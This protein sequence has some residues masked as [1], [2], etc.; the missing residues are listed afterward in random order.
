MVRAKEVATTRR[1]EPRDLLITKN[2]QPTVNLSQLEKAPKN[3]AHDSR[4]RP[5]LWFSRLGMET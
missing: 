3:K 5:F 1:P 4:T 2:S